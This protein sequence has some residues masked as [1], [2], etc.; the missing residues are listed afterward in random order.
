MLAGILVG[1]AAARRLRQ[2]YG[3]QGDSP[4]PHINNGLQVRGWAAAALIAACFAFG[5][6]AAPVAGARTR[7]QLA[8]QIDGYVNQRKFAAA[9]WGVKV[10]STVTGLTLYENH[11][12]RLLSPASNTK[13]YTS[14]LGLVRF[15]G[16]HRI[17]TPI[18]AT[19]QPDAGGVLRG[20]LIV[21]G[22][23][24]WS[25]NSQR[26][27]TNFWDI[28]APFVNA[29]ASHGVRQVTGEIIGDA[30]YFR[31]EPTG[32]SWTIDDLREGEAAEISA[33]TLDDNVMQVSVAPG[34]A[35]GQ[36]CLVTPVQPG[37]GLV[38][39]NQTVTAASGGPER[40]EAFCPSGGKAVFLIGTVPAGSGNQII[41]LPVPE[42]ACWFAAAL[43]MAL[44]RRGIA[45]AGE[46]RGV[47]W[48]RT[49]SWDARTLLKLG[50]VISPPLR[51]MVRDFMKPSQNLEADTLLWDV[52]ES[53][54]SPDTP[55]WMS[56]EAVGLT[57]LRGWLKT[58]DIPTADVQF[59]EG[60]GL[61]RNNLTTASATVALLQFMTRNPEAQDFMESLPISGI[62]GSLR[63][64]FEKDAGTR[65]VRAKTG[66]LRWATALSGYV[67]SAAAERLAFS[68]MLN[69]YEPAPGHSAREEVDA[70]VLMLANFAG[71]SNEAK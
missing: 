13:L 7:K 64:R 29:V 42:P 22:R 5:A 25:W 63:Y 70:L 62:D 51:D 54:R 36:P 57:V 43:K 14:A 33:L 41:D 12:D 19:S 3:G 61:S 47:A 16:S 32:S 40:L 4:G 69:R 53:A 52:G 15:G 20:D 66:T 18:F 56:S 45:V 26:L 24:D 35:V 37:T 39:S 17:A 23:G 46:A 6:H 10:V 38:F 8:S 11:A 27:G 2:S 44:A 65:N 67:T 49:P 50:E 30:T 55:S 9:T 60:S 59:D 21:S 71:R 1:E 58:A 28:F 31:G 34:P 48:P 68:M